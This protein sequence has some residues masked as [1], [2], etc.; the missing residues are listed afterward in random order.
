MRKI[1]IWA[2]ALLFSANNTFAGGYDPVTQDP[3]ANPDAPPY[4]AELQFPSHGDNV[5]GH[6][7]VANGKGPHPT[8]VFLH[9]FP[10]NERDIDLM[11]ALRRA[12]F[13]TLFFHYRGAWGSDGDYSLVHVL[14]DAGTAITL[15]RRLGN[16][17]KHRIDPARISVIGHSLGGFNALVA[18]IEDDALTC[19]VAL[20]PAD[21]YVLANALLDNGFDLKSDV[22]TRPVPGLKNYSFADLIG[23]AV[24]NKARYSLVPRM[25]AFDGRPLLIVS[26]TEDVQVKL[27][28]QLPLVKAA[29]GAKP[30]QHIVLNSDHSFS[31]VRIALMRHITRWMGEN[32]RQ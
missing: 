3:V 12:G 10:G 26:G 11:Q 6:L 24:T 13:N 1:L 2:T 8:V 16:E 19:V 32:C 29:G 17:A 27:E 7:Y 20:A 28:E 4:M 22:N 18:G 15:V 14:E 31:G 5:N 25:S 23:E 9:G 30:F 21:V